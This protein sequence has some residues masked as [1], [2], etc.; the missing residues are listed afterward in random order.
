MFAKFILKCI[1]AL[2][3]AVITA[4]VMYRMAW[5]IAIICTLVIFGGIV[6]I[7][8][9]MLIKHYVKNGTTPASQTQFDEYLSSL[10]RK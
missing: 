3:I 7:P 2:A 9:V 10:R 8:L 4:L 5:I 1:G 6:G